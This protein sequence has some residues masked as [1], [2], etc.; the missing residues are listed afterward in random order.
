M[1]RPAARASSA[2]QD[3]LAPRRQF[4]S[5]NNAGVHPDVLAAIAAAN[6]GH[7][8]AYGDDPYTRSA[9]ERVREHFGRDADVHFVFG[10]T[11]ANVLA[12]RA[13]AQ[14]HQAVICTAGA[15]INVDECGAPEHFTGCKLIAIET[16][17]GKL[18]VEHV[19][20]ELHGLGDEH[21]VQPKV[22][23]ISQATERGTVYT[24]SEIRALA[25]FAHEHGLRLHMDGA[26][27]ANAAAASSTSLRALTTDAG[28]DALS[29]GATKNGAMGA[30][31]VLF[32]N[33][34]RAPEFK[35]IRKQGMQLASKMRFLAVQISALLTDDLWRANAMHSNAMAARLARAL[36]SVPRIEITSPVQANAVFARV[37]REHLDPIRQ[38]FYFYVWNEETCEVRWMTAFDTT[39]KDVDGFVAALREIAT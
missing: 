34:V 15:H 10:G 21:R 39:E 3:S 32:L 4:A 20:R 22:V 30:E 31:A 37:P 24:P 16:R 14:P 9:I 35:F 28:V 2:A 38:R 1:G 26:R 12:L 25:D 5:D 13:L 6:V 27:L 36:A 7:V 8:P 33:G 29:F 18:G 23:A 19:A 11:G 17:D